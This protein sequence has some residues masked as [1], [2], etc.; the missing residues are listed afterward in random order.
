M[1]SPAIGRALAAEAGPGGCRALVIDLQGV[2][3][4]G[5]IGISMLLD[6]RR[7]LLDHGTAIHLLCDP[8]SMP[9]RILRITSLDELFAVHGTLADA[10]VAVDGDRGRHTHR[11]RVDNW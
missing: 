7:T 8:S 6:V 10:L 5:S 11:P 2:T 1:T 9:R 3:F 4:L